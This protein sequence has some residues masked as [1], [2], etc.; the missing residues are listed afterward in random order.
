MILG[1]EGKRRTSLLSLPVPGPLLLY[2]AEFS[3]CKKTPIEK[4]IPDFLLAYLT[5]SFI[6][7]QGPGFEAWIS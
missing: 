2:R 7:S 6:A 4:M 3:L 1:L 5:D